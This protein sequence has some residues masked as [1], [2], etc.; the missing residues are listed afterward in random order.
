[1]NTIMR[2]S[3]LLGSLVFSSSALAAPCAGFTDL[4][5]SSG[6]CT[7]VVW[8]KNRGVTT[9]CSLAPAYCP[10]DVVTRLSMAAFMNRLG[11]KLTTKKVF[12]D[13][14]PGIVN[15]QAGGAFVCPTQAVLAPGSQ[16]EQHAVLHGLAWGLVSAPVTWSAD[17][18][19][20]TNGGATYN[21]ISNFIPTF[22]ATVTGMTSG[23]TFAQL[24]LTPGTP[25]TFAILVRESI[26]VPAGTGNFTDL[27]CHLMVEIGNRTPGAALPPP[28]PTCDGLGP[29]VSCGDPRPGT[30]AG[31]IGGLVGNRRP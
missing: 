6:F 28:P 22:N 9:G 14:N 26:D 16:Y 19:F 11:D 17:L 2:M 4:D 25:Y 1:M 8:M 10:N 5:D 15:I 7:N 29:Q 3:A 13:Q 27:A 31:T 21:F 20:S 24:A 30:V 12:T 18:W 23:S